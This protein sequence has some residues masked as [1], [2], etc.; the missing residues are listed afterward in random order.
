MVDLRILQFSITLQSCIIHFINSN[1]K[2]NY[3]FLNMRKVENKNSYPK[4]IARG[5]RA[6]LFPSL[7]ATNKEQIAVSTLLAT[8]HIVPELL[9]QLIKDVGL[10]ITDKTK[11]KTFTEVNLSKE[12]ASKIN[13]PDGYLYIKNRNEWSALIEAKVGNSKLDPEQICRYLEAAKINNIDAIITISNEFSPRVVQ[14][15]VNIPKKFLN[16]VTLY[17]FSW[18]LILSEASLLKRDNELEDREKSYV[19]EELIRFL[20]DDSVGNK[21]FSMMP[22]SWTS[23]TSNMASDANNIH[24]EETANALVEEFSEIALNLTDHLGVNCTTK[25]ATSFVNDKTLWQKSIMRTIADGKSIVC[26]YNIP[27]AASTLS[28]EID[29]SRST[30]VVGMELQA[31]KDKK[32]VAGKVNWMRRQLVEHDDESFLIKVRWS[33]RAKD[34]F[35]TLNRLTKDNPSLQSKTATIAFFMPQIR[36]HDTRVFKSRKRFI[37]ELEGTVEKFYDNYGQNLKSW[38]AKAPKPIEI[39]SSEDED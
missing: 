1:L 5:N 30:F 25:L 14:S 4:H 8:F 22:P 36:V 16:K 3:L 32:T 9:G 27:N 10:R 6:R 11:F 19:I 17:H 15:P 39:D 35:V 37:S 28:V 33:S 2:L 34:D 13:R 18:R 29:I 7:K 31:P 26:Q 23:I 12:T 38:V 24:L 20:R 21:S